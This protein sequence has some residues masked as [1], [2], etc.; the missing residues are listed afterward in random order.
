MSFATLWI[1]KTVWLWGSFLIIA[2]ITAFQAHVISYLALFPI[3]ALFICQYILTYNVNKSV[4]FLLFCTA[5][6]ISLALLFH[7]LPGFYPIKPY[8]PFDTPF[9]GIFVLALSTPLISSR[10]ALG[11]MLRMTL[12]ILIFL[13]ILLNAIALKI[14]VIHFDFK[15]PLNTP[16]WLAANLFL[17]TIPEEAFFR[18]FIQREVYLF[19]GKTTLAACGAIFIGSLFFI[20]VHLAWVGSLPFLCLIFI[21]SLLYG[22]LYQW[23]GTIES[24]ILCHFLFNATH[25]LLFQ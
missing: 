15:L 9:I 24:S 12:P 10:V 23:T 7:F 17:I 8:A 1:R 22:S 6:L 14:G 19:F 3:T 11:K 16:A 5:T 25:F 20:L 2:I 4:R 13:L 21:T 18:G